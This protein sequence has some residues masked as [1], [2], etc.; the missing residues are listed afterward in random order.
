MNT[1]CEK[2]NTV[3]RLED[4][5]F[6]RCDNDWEH[7]NRIE[8]YNLDN[9]GWGV[10]IDLEETLLEEIQF[11]RVEYGDSEDRTATWLKCYKE[12]KVFIG[13]G[14][15]NILEVILQR[16][17][18]WAELNTDTTPWD[19]VV[20]QLDTEI[21]LAAKDKSFD[22][23]E[24][25]RNIY[26]RIADIPVEHPQRQNLQKKLMMHGRINGINKQPKHTTVPAGRHNFQEKLFEGFFFSQ[27][28]H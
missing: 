26:K 6:T 12:E 4:W 25:L 19:N 16:F 8:I 7:S 18:D 9:P 5:F 1:N 15:Y 24:H 22:T 11:D 2:M 20:S 3:K 17:L 21:R 27:D 10:K 23:K 13:L 28:H 14:S